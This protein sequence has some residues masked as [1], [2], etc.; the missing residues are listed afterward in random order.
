VWKKGS[1][2]FLK[3]DTQRFSCLP[4]FRWKFPTKTAR[5][6]VVGF[7][8]KEEKKDHQIPIPFVWMRRRNL[9]HQEWL[10]FYV[11][12]VRKLW[13]YFEGKN[14]LYSKCGTLTP[15][16]SL[17]ECL[18]HWKF[19]LFMTSK[20]ENWTV[21]YCIDQNPI[22][23]GKAWRKESVTINK[24][25]NHKNSVLKTFIENW[26]CCVPGQD[27]VQKTDKS[28]RCQNR[29]TLGTTATGCFSVTKV[30]SC[31]WRTIC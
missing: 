28:Q 19:I 3:D 25:V 26:E 18:N 10:S 9:F 16:I 13:K 27:H 2:H 21:W 11:S 24:Q 15:R 6:L 1:Q 30:I 29:N 31:S 4:F 14:N 22:D 17:L 20:P 8:V 23:V 5:G 12:F 7:V